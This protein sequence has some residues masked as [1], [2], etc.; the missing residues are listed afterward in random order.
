MSLDIHVYTLNWSA[1]PWNGMFLYCS[2]FESI[3]LPILTCITWS[4]LRNA[5]SIHLLLHIS[6][7][8]NKIILSLK[9]GRP[10][11]H[12]VPIFIWIPWGVYQIAVMEFHLNLI[13][14][15]FKLVINRTKMV[16]SFV[17]KV[18]L[19]VKLLYGQLN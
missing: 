17:H 5:L 3:T 11:T 9:V 7:S 1:P 16:L 10:S 6:Q 18:I 4:K 12:Y 15:F 8:L 19:P 14:K 2:K 13:S